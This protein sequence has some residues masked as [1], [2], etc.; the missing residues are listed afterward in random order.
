MNN[1][2]LQGTGVRLIALVFL[3]ST[4]LIASA[5]C[6][7]GLAGKAGNYDYYIGSG[8][9]QYEQD[10]VIVSNQNDST[11]TS[12]EFAPS[13]S[14]EYKIGGFQAT[15]FTCLST[16]KSPLAGSKY[17]LKEDP[18]RNGA[19]EKPPYYYYQCVAG[20]SEKIP[21]Y[22]DIIPVECDDEG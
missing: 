7:G 19:C 17:L 13:C 22:F 3:I 6:G 21:A 14:Y 8:D 12:S 10:M 20:C 11:S 1:K 15:E 4:P 5:G 2:F 16:S 18:K 9:C